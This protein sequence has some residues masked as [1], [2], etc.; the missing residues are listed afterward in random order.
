MAKPKQGSQYTDEDRYKV[1]LLMAIKGNAT[2]VSEEVGIPART[3]SDWTHT[4]WWVDMSARVREQKDKELDSRWSEIIELATSKVTERLKKGD[5]AKHD[6]DGTVLFKPVSAKDAQMVAAIGYDKRALQRGD[7]TSRT[8][9]VSVE[10]RLDSL[11]ERFTKVSEK[12][13]TNDTI[14]VTH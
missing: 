10:K 9:K 2:R 7:P 6:R 3:I 14:P 13:Q 5:Y 12:A 1:C 4:E 11:T 8:E